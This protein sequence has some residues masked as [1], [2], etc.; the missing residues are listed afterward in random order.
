[1]SAAEPPV[2]A[3][4]LAG[5]RIWPL[6]PYGRLRAAGWEILWPDGGRPMTATCE[7]GADHEAPA[8][9][10]SCGIYAWH[11]RPSSAEALFA[12]CSRGGGAVAGIVA[13][14]GAVEVHRTGFRAQHARPTAFVVDGR[15]ARRGYRRRVSRLADRH[16]ADVV[17]V[18]GPAALYDYCLERG[19]GLRESIVEELLSEQRAEARARRRRRLLAQR[20]AVALCAPAAVGAAALV[21]G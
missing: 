9:D 7:L 1:M 21:L 8:P 2:V 12:E 16:A 3:G 19:L 10:C 18:D 4:E 5:L 17:V 14:W 13:A 15:R 11:P 6:Q 20:A